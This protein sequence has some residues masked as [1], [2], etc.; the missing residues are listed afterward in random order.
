[1][2]IGLILAG[3]SG[4][5][6]GAEM[7]KQFLPLEGRQIILRAIDAFHRHPD[8]D[9]ICVVCGEEWSGRLKYLLE[10]EG[11][12]KICGVVDGGQSRRDSSFRGLTFLMQHFSPDDVVLI[13]DAA[14]PLVS[15]ELITESIRCARRFHACTAAIPLQDTAL[16]SADGRNA[17]HIPDRQRLYAV[18]TPQTFRLGTIYDA[19]RRFPAERDAT[20]DAGILI[21]QGANVKLVPGEKRNLKITSPEDLEIAAVF[22]RQ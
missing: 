4:V 1:M 15:G 16:E 9:S 22:L 20:D 6:M 18:Q 13:H 2:N 19:H 14:R 3:G 7:P 21:A 11:Y 17:G 5:R 8:V 12:E 10:Q